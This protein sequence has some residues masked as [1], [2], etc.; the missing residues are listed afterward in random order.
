MGTLAS[1]KAQREDLLI[2]KCYFSVA[3]GPFNLDFFGVQLPQHQKVKV[4]FG[5]VRQKVLGLRLEPHRLVSW[6]VER[7]LEIKKEFWLGL[8]RQSVSRPVSYP[9]VYL[10]RNYYSE[11]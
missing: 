9:R 2:T 1:R 11:H 6:C 8:A 3:D 10:G 7:L 4:N 5:E